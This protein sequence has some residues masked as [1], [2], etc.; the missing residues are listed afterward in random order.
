MEF[1]VKT[2][3]L[4]KQRTPCLVLGI[5]ER[6]K[7]SPPAEA[8][9]EASDGRLAAILKR[10]DLNGDIGAT[11]CLYD[12]PGIAAERVLLVGCGKR[13]ELDQ[14]R[15]G[16]ACTAA[17]R[18]LDA[19]GAGEAL[20]TLPELAP[21][22]LDRY[23]TTRGAVTA[24]AAAVYRYTRTKDDK[25]A[26]KQPLKRLNVWLGKKGEEAAA[27][28]G[29]SHGQA[30][31][32]GV[33][34][35]RELGNLPGN[36]C[37]PTYLAEQAEALG[38]EFS[39]LRVEVLE[40]ADME[41]LG[42]GAL[43][44]VSRGSRQPAKLIVMEHRGGKK[45]DKPVVLV[46]KGLTFDAGGISL[47]PAAEMDEMKYDMCG[48]A[49]VF[50]AVRAAAELDLPINLIGVVPSSENLPDGAA[51][52]PGDIVKSLSGQTIEILNTDAEG[53]LILCDALTYCERFEPAAVIDMAT[54]T[55]A[56]VVALGKHPAGLFTSD[57][58]LA[59]EILAAGEASG[60]RAWR[61]PLWDDYQSQ[62]DSNFADMANIGG[63]EAGAVTA[64]CFLSRYTK[65]Y[66]WAHL[67]I[68]G[69]AWLGGKEKGATGRPVSLLAEL[70]LR[71]AGALT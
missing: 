71:R 6:R 60:D 3:A 19:M 40:E 37:T 34:L 28:L 56:C 5:F 66:R 57:D 33:A 26:P 45:G 23:R 24:T 25:K 67:D 8:I 54:L 62:L 18:A 31:A 32:H 69:I 46:G 35:A 65:K 52:K 58:K 70:L 61:L 22:G 9:D 44:S 7:L 16:Q 21:N 13:R 55:G 49:S 42:M 10:G 27:E 64:A 63:R 30:V 29:I 14:A 1:S 48:G 51:N 4:A 39:K 50:G 43:L 15:Y 59:D 47:K 36:I 11:L 20:S 12:V 38:K 68:A 41:T 53:R 17:A 2:G